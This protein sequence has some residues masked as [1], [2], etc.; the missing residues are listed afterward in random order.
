MEPVVPPSLGSCLEGIGSG[1]TSSSIPSC[2]HLDSNP[3]LSPLGRHESEPS[4]PASAQSPS[5]SS[6]PERAGLAELKLSE[7]R[8]F[9]REVDLP[10]DSDKFLSFSN[11]VSWASAPELLNMAGQWHWDKSYGQPVH[12]NMWELGHDLPYTTRDAY[13][14]ANPP[15]PT[16]AAECDSSAAQ[17]P[18][19]A[20]HDGNSHV[21]T[22][23]YE[24][25]GASQYRDTHAAPF[26]VPRGCDDDGLDDFGNHQDH[27]AF[28]WWPGSDTE[29]LDRRVLASNEL[30]AANLGS[31]R[32][33]TLPVA[34]PES[35]QR[36]SLPR[37]QL[38]TRVLSQ[39]ARYADT[40]SGSVFAHD[41]GPPVPGY[42][43]VPPPARQ[44]D[45][46]PPTGPIATQVPLHRYR[47]LQ[48]PLQ[49]DTP[50]LHSGK[51]FCPVSGIG[52]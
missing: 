48:R 44:P 23:P 1:P 8:P 18:S 37:S 32:R 11:L 38:S 10:A 19:Q 17:H 30:P 43:G 6:S 36:L 41:H 20:R 2:F 50:P 13:D 46:S 7:V 28:T 52:L 25:Y 21:N 22:V 47:E 33:L 45:M 49:Q 15:S 40:Y 27:Q 3:F 5:W 4:L 29:V 42:S 31:T 9:G 16:Y 34:H 12:P 24:Q 26:P 51:T 35:N 14:H 39:P